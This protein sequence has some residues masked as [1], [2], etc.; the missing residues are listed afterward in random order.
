MK[1]EAVFAIGID[2]VV[3][4]SISVPANPGRSANMP[5]TPRTANPLIQ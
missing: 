4:V 1:R 3:I 5:A 2:E